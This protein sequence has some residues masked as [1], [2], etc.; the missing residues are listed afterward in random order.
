MLQKP[1]SVPALLGCAAW[2]QQGRSSV[3]L[4]I[5][6]HAARP[7]SRGSVLTEGGTMLSR[8]VEESTGSPENCPRL[9]NYKVQ[10]RG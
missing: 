6:A 5:N 2:Y 1:Q 8:K 7:G 9:S 10:R 4:V 3:Y